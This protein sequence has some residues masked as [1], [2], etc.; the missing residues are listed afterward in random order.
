MSEA[1]AGGDNSA[2]LWCW[3]QYFIRQQKQGGRTWKERKNFRKMII[4]SSD[5]DESMT[6]RGRGMQ[7]RERQMSRISLRKYFPFF[8]L[9]TRVLI[10]SFSHELSELWFWSLDL[11]IYQPS[12]LSFISSCVGYFITY[13]T[14]IVFSFLPFY[15]IGQKD[16]QIHKWNQGWHTDGG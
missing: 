10:F 8:A 12:C 2:L 14:F 11:L 7:G 4:P 13:S 15:S 5:G 1:A 6:R 9:F 3:K 16:R